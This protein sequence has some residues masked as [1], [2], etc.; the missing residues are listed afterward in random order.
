MSFYLRHMGMGLSFNH[1]RLGLGLGDPGRCF[2]LHLC[3]V[4]GVNAYLRYLNLLM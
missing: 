3:M 1:G 2:A 4:V